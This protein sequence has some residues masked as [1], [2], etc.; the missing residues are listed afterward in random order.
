VSEKRFTLLSAELKDP[1]QSAY[2]VHTSRITP[3]NPPLERRETG[4]SSSLPFL[5]GGLGWGK[6]RI[7]Q[8]LETCVYTV[9]TMGRHLLSTLLTQHSELSTQH[10]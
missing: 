1:P 9:A 6:T 4:K 3:L 7:H 10:S 2:G 8:L 5:R